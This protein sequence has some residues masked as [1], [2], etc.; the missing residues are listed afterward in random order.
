MAVHVES[1]ETHGAQNGLP[2][3]IALI[4]IS[5]AVIRFLS[6]EHTFDAVGGQ[7][8]GMTST[9][10]GVHE[11]SDGPAMIMTRFD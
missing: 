1:F 4:D 5:N 11:E 3:G 2:H 10:N 9:D 8:A 7:D 6:Y